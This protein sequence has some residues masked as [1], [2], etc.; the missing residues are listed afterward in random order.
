MNRSSKTA[1]AALTAAGV[2]VGV[3]LP[4]GTSA[5]ADGP[6]P[7]GADP[8]AVGRRDDPARP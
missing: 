8:G 5:A 2:L 3:W 6:R 1:A 7:A 4:A